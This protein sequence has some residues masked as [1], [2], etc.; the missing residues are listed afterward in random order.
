MK[1]DEST[2]NIWYQEK[3]VAGLLVTIIA[4]INRS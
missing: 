3:K 2:Y 1:L 4:V